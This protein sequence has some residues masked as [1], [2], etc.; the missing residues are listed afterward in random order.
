[1][2]DAP[3]ITADWLTDPVAQKVIRSLTDAGHAAFFVGGCVRNALLGEPVAD[4]DICTAAMPETVSDIARNAGFK[5]V[6]T[7]IDH[8]TVTVVAAGRPFE[9]TTFRRDVDTDGRRATVA[10]SDRMEDDAHRRD[11]TMNALY[12]GPDGAV[13]D[14]VGGLPDLAARRVR[15]IG[16]PH[17]RIREDALRILRFFRF[18]AWY[19]DPDGGIDAEGLAACAAH[20]DM[21]DR[22]SRERIG[23]EMRRLLAAPDPAPALA[24]FEHTGGLS[25]ILPGAG[26]DLLTRF[27]GSDADPPADPLR[28]LALVGGEDVADR[29]RLSR[30]EAERLDLYR[31]EMAAQ[32]RPGELGYRHGAEAA[33]AILG[34]RSVLGGRLP[35]AADLAEAEAGARAVFPL[36]AADLM[37]AL[38]GPALGAA[39]KAAERRWIDSGFSLTRDDLLS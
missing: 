24:S 15:F 35:T 2:P 8:G 26:T 4:I 18:H 36:K 6:P 29:L 10:Y 31:R 30:A 32:T 34:L 13:L 16:D 39:L 1:M 17:A 7:G 21:L 3:R 27:T 28:R 23:H 11:F 20:V 12:A 25:H 19:G 37:P 22:L 33:R 38:Q 9:I 5:A 14:P